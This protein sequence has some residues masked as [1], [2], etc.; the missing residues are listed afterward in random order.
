MRLKTRLRLK[1]TFET[2]RVNSVLRFLINKLTSR[3]PQLEGSL[4]ITQSGMWKFVEF[5]TQNSHSSLLNVLVLL[6][7]RKE[8]WM[9]FWWLLN[10]CDDVFG[11]WWYCLVYIIRRWAAS[12][13]LIFAKRGDYS[14][15]HYI[16]HEDACRTDNVPMLIIITI[17]GHCSRCRGKV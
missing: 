8:C 12:K 17:K 1:N 10:K 7:I 5:R 16:K 13:L 9:V 3:N 11:L 15:T 6:L 2:A 14:N 4:V